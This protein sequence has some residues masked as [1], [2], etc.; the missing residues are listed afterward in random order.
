MG[1]ETLCGGL[2]LLMLVIS[3]GVILLG[4]GGLLLLR[5]G[6]IGSYLIKGKND[7]GES[8]DYALDQSREPPADGASEKSPNDAG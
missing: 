8:Q 2:T 4:L 3:G 5:L 6:V 1:A 7:R